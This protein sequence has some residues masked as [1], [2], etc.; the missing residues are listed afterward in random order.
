[1]RSPFTYTDYIMPT[2][3]SVFVSHCSQGVR[4]PIPTQNQQLRRYLSLS[5]ASNS[6]SQ[7]LNEVQLLW[8]HIYDKDRYKKMYTTRQY[9]FETSRTCKPE[10]LTT[11][12]KSIKVCRNS[13]LQNQ[14]Q[15]HGFEVFDSSGNL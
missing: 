4:G 2:E 15:Q 8:N 6:V 13:V 12:T 5:E 14:Q 11:V 7:T 3:R 1:M 10:P 9:P